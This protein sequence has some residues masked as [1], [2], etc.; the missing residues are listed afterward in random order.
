MYWFR[1]PFWFDRE[2]RHRHRVVDVAFL[3]SLVFLAG[4]LAMA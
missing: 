3:L 4:I 1:L 2:I